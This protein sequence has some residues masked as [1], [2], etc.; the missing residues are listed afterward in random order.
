MCD[1]V[2]SI[3]DDDILFKK[4]TLGER[5][6]FML[7]ATKNGIGGFV[8]FASICQPT[9]KCEHLAEDKI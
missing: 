3:I 6:C 8:S 4:S 7:M 5:M 1:W 2:K 9:E